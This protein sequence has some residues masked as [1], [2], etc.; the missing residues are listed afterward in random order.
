MSQQLCRADLEPAERPGLTRG[1]HLPSP[2]AVN[3]LQLARRR[4]I[5]NL[6]FICDFDKGGETCTAIGLENDSDC[7]RFWVAANTNVEHKTVPF[8]KIVL[9]RLSASDPR[10]QESKEEALT[11]FTIQFASKRI[12]GEVNLLL[13][14]IADC[15]DRINQ[16]RS[17]RGTGSPRFTIVNKS[18]GYTRF[19]SPLRAIGSAF[20]EVYHYI[21]RLA[22]HI[23][24]IKE[25]VNDAHLLD[26]LFSSY[27]VCP[28][29]GFECVPKPE[30]D[31]DTTLDG[32]LNR[33]LSNNPKKQEYEKLLSQLDQNHKIMAQIMNCYNN[34]NFE[35]KVH[36][37]IQVLTHF[38]NKGIS[39]VNNDRYIGCS[40]PACFCC[41]LYIRHHPARMVVPESHQK[42]WLNWGPPKLQYGSKDLGFVQQRNV[43]N[44]VIQNIRE[45]VI[46]EIE[47]KG[48]SGKWH[49][50]SQTGITD[51]IGTNDSFENWTD[52]DFSDFDVLENELLETPGSSPPPTSQSYVGTSTEEEDSD[53]DS[54][55]GVLLTS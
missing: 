16:Q 5:R 25:L 33:M 37:E 15:R 38:D 9:E 51:S 13:K 12:V 19:K 40:K 18:S 48:S 28:V 44:K 17:E 49:P 21:G 2:E 4:F 23:R 55:G 52:S 24:V 7:Y 31:L 35:P 11:R 6:S 1:G 47:Q 54:E 14:A 27:E 30:P 36:A 41:Y 29:P 26:P 45:G 32:I 34:E 46:D 53:T 3:S 22:R 20:T 8:L 10:E 43:L 42:I 39:Y 50:D